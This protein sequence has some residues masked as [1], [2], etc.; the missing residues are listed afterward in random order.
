MN[1]CRRTDSLLAEVF[2]GRALTREQREHAT[3]CSECARVLALSRRF[4]RELQTAVTAMVPEPTTAAVAR[5]DDAPVPHRGGHQMWQRTMV[6]ITS[7]ALAVAVIALGSGVLGSAPRL[8]GILDGAVS[9]DRLDAWLDRALTVAH[10]DAGRETSPLADWEAAQ[11]ETCGDTAIAFFVADNEQAAYLWALGKVD[12]LFDRSIATGSTRSLGEPEV[13][14]R[15]A[16]L[17]V[18]AVALGKLQAPA[19]LIDGLP[20][21]GQ[22]VALVPGLAWMGDPDDAPVEVEVIGTGAEPVEVG[23]FSDPYLLGRV[24]D[25]AIRA[26]DVLTPDGRYRYP[27]AAPGFM[28]GADVVDAATHFEYLDASGAAVDAGPILEWE[29]AAAQRPGEEQRRAQAEARARAQAAAEHERRALETG[30]AG[31]RCG[32]WPKLSDEEQ[33]A[34]TAVVVTDLAAARVGQQLP[35]SASPERIIAAARASLDK[36]CQGAPVDRAV[37]DIARALYGD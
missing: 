21:G 2:A 12:D 35:A 1:R 6:A 9:P 25:P 11:I 7:A 27:A 36:G 5:A 33:L 16:E 24:S 14:R 19:E 31:Y 34:V 15:R 22:G 23:V 20:F 30:Q 28:V 26:V 29:R 17:A 3:D 32:E 8:G 37:A 4:E 13:A 10:A 18:C